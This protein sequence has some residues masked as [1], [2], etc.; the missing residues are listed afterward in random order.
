[1]T[2]KV[3][4]IITLKVRVGPLVFC[5]MESGPSSLFAKVKVGPLKLEF[6]KSEVGPPLI[7][8]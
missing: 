1:M 8:S 5:E 4:T 3:V 2:V 7:F 6:K